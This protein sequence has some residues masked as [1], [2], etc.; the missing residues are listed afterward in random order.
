M[1]RNADSE[2]VPPLE[3]IAARGDRSEPSDWPEWMRKLGQETRRMRELMGLSQTQLAELAGVSQGSV[4]RLE[5]GRQV[6][7]SLLVVLKT[8]LAL[9]RLVRRIDPDKPVDRF[10]ILL[11]SSLVAPD[12]DVEVAS[13]PLKTL[14]DDP[15]LDELIAIY[16]RLPRRHRGALLS[17]ARASAAAMATPGGD[18]R[19]S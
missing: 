17:I 11:A 8:H 6:S 16:R 5:A 14:T 2:L 19:S 10:P 3:A 12:A 4:S 18:P 7:T 13:L 9:V 15:D 1:E